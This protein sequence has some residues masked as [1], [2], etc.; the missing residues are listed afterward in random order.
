MGRRRSSGRKQVGK[1]KVRLAEVFKCP[2]CAHEKA[3]EV[4]MCVVACCGAGASLLSASSLL[5][6]DLCRP[7][8]GGMFVISH[9]GT[10]VVALVRSGAASVTSPSQHRS[11]VRLA[12]LCPRLRA[13]SLM[14]AH[15]HARLWLC[16][17]VAV[18]LCGCGCVRARSWAVSVVRCASWLRSAHA[19]AA[20]C[21]L[22]PQI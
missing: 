1:K 14:D 5:L 20:T 10:V 18:W 15:I 6:R 8:C 7:G 17:A 13:V 2:F 16:V 9:P 4:K 11:I 22:Q 12:V 3:C 19:A 21:V